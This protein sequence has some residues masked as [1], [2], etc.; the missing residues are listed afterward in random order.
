MALWIDLNEYLASF[1][2]TALTD[3]ISVTELNEIR[4]NSMPNIWSKQAYVKGF[5]R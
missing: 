2:G 1:P 5:G 4:L 3:K